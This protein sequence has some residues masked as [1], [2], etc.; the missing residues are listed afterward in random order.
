MPNVQEIFLSVEVVVRKESDLEVTGRM[1]KSM[2]RCY[3]N[4]DQ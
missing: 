4:G 2:L 1:K 3:S